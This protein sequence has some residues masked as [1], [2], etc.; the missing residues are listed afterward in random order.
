VLGAVVYYDDDGDAE[1][2]DDEVVD[3]H[4]ADTT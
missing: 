2:V 4:V 3:K 1:G